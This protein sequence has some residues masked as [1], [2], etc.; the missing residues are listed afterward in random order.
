G[1]VEQ[2][3]FFDYQ[4][5]LEQPRVEVSIEREA[6]LATIRQPHVFEGT[7]TIN[8]IQRVWIE[9]EGF[10]A[11]SGAG[12]GNSE[13]DLR[14]LW[15][16]HGADADIRMRLGQTGGRFPADGQP[17]VH[18]STAPHYYMSF[19]IEIDAGAETEFVIR[20]DYHSDDNG[21]DLRSEKQRERSYTEPAAEI[22]RQRT[23]WQR[24]LQHEVPQIRCSDAGLE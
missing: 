2:W 12:F 10:T 23:S 22:A 17:V 6:G 18:S 24:H 16:E 13:Q 5:Q 19:R 14:A 3:P 20:S 11:C 4:K 9:N 7:G 21:G 15:R 1:S 8:S